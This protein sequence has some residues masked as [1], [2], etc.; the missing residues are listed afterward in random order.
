MTGQ[1]ISNYLMTSQF[2]EISYSLFF[3]IV[4]YKKKL[5]MSNQLYYLIKLKKNI[6]NIKSP[7]LYNDMIIL[8]DY[9]VVLDNCI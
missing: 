4:K 5:V 6:I 7:D 9:Y 8:K 3:T 1:F 2:L